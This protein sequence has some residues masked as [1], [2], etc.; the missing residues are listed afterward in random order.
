MALIGTPGNDSV[1]VGEVDTTTSV[2]ED[3][4]DVSNEAIG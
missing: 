4:V 2:D 3:D 1:V